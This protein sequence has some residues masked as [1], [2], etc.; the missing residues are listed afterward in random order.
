MRTWSFSKKVFLVG[1]IFVATL[2]GISFAGLAG[3]VRLEKSITQFANGF[4]TNQV[5]SK[6]ES[7]PKEVRMIEAQ[8]LIEPSFEQFSTY[9]KLMNESFKNWELA[10]ET[11]FGK[12][13]E[14]GLRKNIGELQRRVEKRKE[15]SEKLIKAAFDSENESAWTRL[16]E[17]EV[18]R[19]L[20]EKIDSLSAEI[21]NAERQTVLLIKREALNLSKSWLYW[22]ALM[23][24][25]GTG[26]GLMLSQS[27]LTGLTRNLNRLADQSADATSRIAHFSSEISLAGGG[28]IQNST[29]QVSALEATCTAIERL[30]TKVNLYA[31]QAKQAADLA[32]SGSDHAQK[33]KDA[34]DQLT[35]AL[36][37]FVLHSSEAFPKY[38]ESE[39][40]LENIFSA[41][42]GLDEKLKV[43]QEFSLQAKV[44]SLNAAAEA[45]RA[46]VQGRGFAI[47]ADEIGHLHQNSAKAAR[48]LTC[49]FSECHQQIEAT[50]H[51]VQG[52]IAALAT[53]GHEKIEAGH[54]LA[55][56]C[57]SAMT[58]LAGKNSHLSSVAVGM[59]S[60]YDN[61]SEGIAEIS[62]TMSQLAWETRQGINHAQECV[63]TTQELSAQLDGMQSIVRQLVTLVKGSTLHQKRIRTN[64]QDNEHTATAI[65][66]DLNTS[67]SSTEPALASVT[68]SSTPLS[69]EKHLTQREK[70]VPKTMLKKAAGAEDISISQDDA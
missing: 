6:L 38:K 46:G 22:L 35:L 23:T 12:T 56:Q 62:K 25:I 65:E 54:Q 18:S 9:S 7:F 13:T 42:R 49:V 30:V 14:D 47:I 34:L 31:E 69:S 17:D 39:K 67:P 15:L 66:L 3:F 64:P 61:E 28:L 16:K 53:H 27:I 19:N 51:S 48:E 36:K 20:E 21:G 60:A 43:F 24:F 58:E 33:T 29:A 59:S 2:L 70:A 10:L 8:A 50:V 55:V 26:V 11:A 41:L 37:D 1:V 4:E 68:M 63:T 57:S 32:V 40:E 5:I 45:A 52:K 44:L